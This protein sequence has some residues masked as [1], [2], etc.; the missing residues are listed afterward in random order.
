MARK[1][2]CSRKMISVGQISAEI[3][4]RH[5]NYKCR[6]CRAIFIY[7]GEIHFYDKKRENGSV[8]STAKAKFVKGM[9]PEKP[10]Q[11][12]YYKG[13]LHS[14]TRSSNNKSNTSHIGAFLYFLEEKNRGL[15]FNLGKLLY[16]VERGF[17]DRR[18]PVL[19]LPVYV[20][21]CWKSGT[22]KK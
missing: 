17:S 6:S 10:C 8:F 18:Y 4:H 12:H 20:G 16:G 3:C 19:L 5:R 2:R 11:H 22:R 7:D 21:S 9:V 15:L 13:K 1:E 14:P